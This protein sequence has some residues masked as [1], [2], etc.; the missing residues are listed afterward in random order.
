[1]RQAP[2]LVVLVALEQDAGIRLEAYTFEDEQ[3]LRCWLAG[4][5]QTLTRI[6][7]ELLALLNTLLDERDLDTGE[8]A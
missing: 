7:A 5:P 3:R 2:R 8:A 6:V 4:S 1:M